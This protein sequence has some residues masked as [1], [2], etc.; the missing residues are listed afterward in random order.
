[1][2]YRPDGNLE[3]LGR[4]DHQ[5]KVRGVRIELGEIEA[6]LSQYPA[7]RQAVVAVRDDT[8]AERR[9][10]AY[11]TTNDRT[12]PSVR[13]LRHFLKERLPDPMVP[14]AFV[15]LEVL[16]LTPGG[17]LDRRALPPPEAGR[18]GLH[19]AYVAPR[20]AVEA[21]L[22]EIWAELLGIPAVGVTDDFFDLGGH[23]L[24]TPRV[25]DRIHRTFQIKVPL[26]ALF[27]SP[28]VAGLARELAAREPQAGWA[29][30]IARELRAKH[31]CVASS[32]PQR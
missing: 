2:R 31:I 14:T 7:V 25:L 10:V 13:E 29:A 17:K 3:F 16:P 19:E 9:L 32:K 6:A 18:G 21:V 30:Q 22:A 1:V 23:S 26:C 11:L 15:V 27:R 5:V 12:A 4:L 28:T 8:P 20:T 24:L